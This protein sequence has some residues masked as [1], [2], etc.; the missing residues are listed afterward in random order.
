MDDDNH[1]SSVAIK[2][3]EERVNILEGKVQTRPIRYVT[4]INELYVARVD[5]TNVMRDQWLE[6]RK[7]LDITASSID[8]IVDVTVLPENVIHLTTLGFYCERIPYTGYTKISFKGPLAY[9]TY[10]DNID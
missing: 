6:I 10:L 7:L 4:N 3:L 2:Q 8:I 9:S 1:V 5:Y